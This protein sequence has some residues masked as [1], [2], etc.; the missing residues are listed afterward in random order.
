MGE[1]NRKGTTSAN[2]DKVVNDF[3]EHLAPDGVPGEVMSIYK[4]MGDACYCA[5]VAGK[6][7]AQRMQ[8]EGD[9]EA[10]HV[11]EIAMEFAKI[12]A[13]KV[14][15]APQPSALMRPQVGTP[16]GKIMNLPGGFCNN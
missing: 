7:A 14:T 8:L 11:L 4:A 10:D 15:L 2:R 5:F 3:V 9:I 12:I 13:M 16:A 6:M 1:K